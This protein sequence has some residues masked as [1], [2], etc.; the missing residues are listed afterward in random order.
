MTQLIS[1][2]IVLLTAFA[3]SAVAAYVSVDGM[4]AIFAASPI[5]GYILFT[6]LEVGKLVAAQW[7]K[8]NWTNKKV[9]IAHKAYMITAVVVLMIVTAF[10][11]YGFL[12]KSHLEH[13]AP[14]EG[15]ALQ[16]AQK[17]QSIAQ[18]SNDNTRLQSRLDQLDANINSFLKGDKADR[19]NQ[20]RR[21]QQA[22]RRDIEKEMKANNEKINSLNSELLPLK[23]KSSDV[24]AKL[25]PIKFVAELF[26]WQD[27]GAAVRM[28][29]L[30]IMFSFDP[31]A[32]IM[33]LSGFITLSDW[34][35]SRKKNQEPTPPVVEP[36]IEPITAPIAEPLAEPVI[37]E[38]LIVEPE[39][40]TQ[41]E[42]VVEPV[43]EEP[44]VEEPTPTKP[45]R[46]YKRKNPYQKELQKVAAL[47]QEDGKTPINQDAKELV[48]ILERR[49]DLLNDV[50]DVVMD[51]SK[52]KMVLPISEMIEADG[53]ERNADSL[54]SNVPQEQIESNIRSANTWLANAKSDR[55]K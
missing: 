35:D 8:S 32:V 4:V 17:E 23:M 33:M 26:G 25:G 10:G 12:A 40:E 45:K 6:T 16:V 42:E 24:T 41:P 9:S 29:I 36:I 28:L 22:E 27:T 30:M 20:V 15:I 21:T 48:E 18:V 7:L 47:Y 19:A 53:K 34:R 55:T 46:Q 38:E 31:L 43:V 37:Q 50:I 54:I 49:P 5:I 51:D 14:I 39:V 1:G 13:A 11:I 44:P 2:I 3:I 52:K